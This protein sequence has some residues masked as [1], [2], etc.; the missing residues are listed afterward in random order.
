VIN[1]NKKKESLMGVKTRY[2]GPFAWLLLEGMSRFY[3]AYVQD[4]ASTV[5][6]KH[7]MHDLLVEC[8]YL[9]GFVLPCIYCRISY[10]QFT[11]PAQ[12]NNRGTNVHYMLMLNSKGQPIRKD[13][14]KKLIYN[15]HQRVSQK[16]RGQERE[17]A[18]DQPELLAE[19]NDKWH[20]HMITY[21]EALQRKYPAAQSKRF[22]Y[23]LIVFLG[24]CMC[25]YRPNEGCY[26]YRFFLVIG[27][28]LLHA[29]DE[30][31]LNLAKAY[32]LSLEKGLPFWKSSMSMGQRLDIVWLIKKYVFALKGWKFDRTRSSFEEKCREGIVG[33]ERKKA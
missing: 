10:Q 25:D 11:D 14:A 7:E 1:N 20:R 21:E 23:A 22:W 2:F 15:L 18:A 13:G 5:E 27:R 26:I 6:Q 3:D 29:T 19:I 33:C 8:M 31:T 4:E 28:I 17:K 24:L 32:C 16:L 9:L 12:V 30:P